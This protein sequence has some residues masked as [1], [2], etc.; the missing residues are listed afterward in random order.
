MI[1]CIPDATM[2]ADSATVNPS[3]TDEGT[4]ESEGGD[5]ERVELTVHQTNYTTRTRADGSETTVLH[6][7]GRRSDGKLYHVAIHHYDPYFYTPSGEASPDDHRAIKDIEPVEIPTLQEESVEKVSV[8]IPK[9]IKRFRNQYSTHYEADIPYPDRYLIDNGFREGISVPSGEASGPGVGDASDPIERIDITEPGQ[10]KPYSPDGETSES[11]L[12]ILDIEVED[13]NG[14]PEAEDA[15][16]EIIS[17]SSWDSYHD[18]YRILIQ[19]HDN[20][21]QIPE[22]LPGYTPISEEVK[23][24]D[25]E[26]DERHDMDC[27]VHVFDTEADMLVAFLNYLQTTDPDLICGWNMHDFDAKYIVNRL[28]AVDSTAGRSRDEDC[29]D[30]LNDD[31]LSRVGEVWTG[32]WR[33]GPDVKGRVVFDLLDAYKRMQ[34]SELDSY[35][36]EAVGQEVFGVGKEYH[37]GNV[38]DLW[39]DDPER[40]LEYNLRDVEL[41]VELNEQQG[42]IPFWEEV[43]DIAGCRLE[44][45]T[46]PSDVVDRYIL[47]KTHD[48]YAL[49]SRGQ[50]EGEDFE[51]GAVFDPV[52][53]VKEN[54]VVLDLASLYPMSMSTIN[55]SPETKVDPDEYDGET[56]HAPNGIHYR[57]D[58]DGIIREVIDEL[59]TERDEKKRLR[60]QHEPGTGEYEK[61][62]RQ[63]ASVKV[64]MNSLY[65]VLGWDR[66]RLYDKE[67]AAAITSTGREVLAFTEKVVNE[68]GYEVL[69][70]DTDSVM[71]C[72][73]PDLTEDEV[74]ER[75]RE[76]EKTINERYDDF[77]REG[78]DAED[79]RFEVE[80]EK[81][82][83]RFF[84]AG[85]KKRY[86]GHIVWEE[87][88]EMDEVDITGFEYKRSDIAPVTKKVQH[89]VIDMIVH[90]AALEDIREQLH[91][92]I[93]N[94]RSGEVSIEDV[95]IPMGI[96]QPL[97]EYDNDPA[98]VRGARYANLFL[99]TNF[100]HGSKPKRLY[101]D[102]VDR[103]FFEE[104]D[105]FETGAGVESPVSSNQDQTD[106]KNFRRETDVI[107][108]E[109]DEEI[110]D[111]FN[112]DWD[113][114][115]EKT[116]KGPISRVIEPLGIEWDNVK[117]GQTQEGLDSFM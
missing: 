22:T 30:K 37:D 24:K 69:Y 106:K 2:S 115:L 112:I 5:E 29:H 20:S 93:V 65:G 92:V 27:A 77:A 94:F 54:V 45:A 72:F 13:R 104:H 107:C 82:Y 51:G 40:L 98:H 57:T 8:T 102:G 64:L 31:A 15:H 23:D 43:A 59:L 50:K 103:E 12:N 63:Q 58:Q 61:F 108:F 44:D 87:G 62:D 32:G 74:K 117:A 79:H 3:Q 19:K 91:E 28:D 110:P 84:Q 4:N 111:T 96:G 18:E 83:R 49:Q 53:G 34:F 68:L 71:I 116:L 114:M 60:D 9:Y 52:S 38:G 17:I 80:F 81:L 39:E 1:Q 113:R 109:H 78:L 86:A 90:G 89:E 85:K 48:Q 47:R 88:N 101:L 76:M 11:H 25:D 75:A 97:D 99:G 35:R 33:G 41:C 46:V 26:D 67:N 56:R 100:Q 14:F 10:I 55:A 73:G 66:F 42:I 105:A 70:G 6:L 36:L 7:F 16:E 95:G 21:P